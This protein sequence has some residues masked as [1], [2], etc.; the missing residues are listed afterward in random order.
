MNLYT[1]YC[2]LTTI[3]YVNTSFDVYFW[4]LIYLF[5]ESENPLIQV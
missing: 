3:F 1:F 5:L 4:V 2:F